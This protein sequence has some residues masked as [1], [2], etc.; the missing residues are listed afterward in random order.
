MQ[1]G[2]P[3]VKKRSDACFSAIRWNS[4]VRNIAAGA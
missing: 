4:G 1:I 3:A 2:A